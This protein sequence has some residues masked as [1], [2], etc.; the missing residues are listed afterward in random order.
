MIRD[1]LANRG[2]VLL[3]VVAIALGVAATV[4]S[5]IM[6][7]SI[8]TSLSVQHTRADVGVSVQMNSTGPAFSAP[9]IARLAAL[10]E[11]VRATGVQR[12]RAGVVAPNGKLVASA[13]VPEQAGTGWDD[14]GRFT[15][16]AGRAPHAGEIAVERATAEAGGLVL[17][18]DATVLL[19][20][21]RRLTARIVG[22]FDYRTLGPQSA[23]SDDET[24]ADQVPVAAFAA[25]EV[26]SVLSGDL[27]RIELALRPGADPVGVRNQAA[28]LVPQGHAFTGDQPAQAAT[29]EAKSE[30]N[31]LRLVLLPLS[32]IIVLVGIF[33]ITNSFTMLA[34]QRIRQFALLRAVG[35]HR[36]QIQAATILEAVGLAL[37]GGTLGVLA[38][39]GLA[40]LLLA[41]MRPDQ[42]I[43]YAGFPVAVLLGYAVA[44]V[45]TILAASGATRRAGRV[46][47]LAALRL[48]A[49]SPVAERGLRTW[50]GTG[51]VLAGVGLVLLTADPSADNQSRIIGL[52]GAVLSVIGV[53]MLSPR[54][55]A[56]G[57]PP[58]LR[59]V[60][61]WSGP[62]LRL[63]VR[64][65]ARNPRRT[66]G[67]GIA[68]TI[69]LT[70][71]CAFATLSATLDSLVGSSVRDNVPVSTT[72]LRS[73]AGGDSVLDPETLRAIAALPSVRTAAA[74][75][76]VYADIDHSGGTD[77]R[78][79]SIVEPEAIG[80]VLTPELIAGS[81]DLRSGI[82][83]SRNQADMLGLAVRDEVTLRLPGSTPIR[84]VV[85]GI[86]E[87]TEL[88]SSV[89]LDVNRVPQRL[90]D[91]ITL[92]YATGVDPQQARAAIERAVGDRP[93]I[94]VLD[95]DVLAD[96]YVRAQRFGFVLLYA[97][98]GL[99][100]LVA[101]FGVV[102]T[103]LLSVWERIPEIGMLRAIG[104]QRRLIQRMITAESLLICAFGAV[105][106]VVVGLW[107]GMVMQHV[108]FGQRILDATIPMGTI[109]LAL[110]GMVTAAV[111][112][113]FWPA[114]QASRV[115]VL[116][117][118]AR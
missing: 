117:A 73:A 96:D 90:Q 106:G 15:L 28:L 53:V 110:L 60:G 35:A 51:A 30:A 81:A 11:V 18:S 79:V 63:G 66:A 56:V 26:A 67:T 31:D 62:A 34:T 114:R 23:E 102:N 12:G 74:T 50:V 47:P 9:D 54:L 2:R 59:L 92:I 33:V 104:A 4:G 20:E 39:V 84:S 116:A 55:A 89:Y 48:D 98:F 21:Q 43:V 57:L 64:N 24:S 1:L 22:F 70:L 111:L 7:D 49:V 82:L 109:A 85:T 77:I 44:L 71:V 13:T 93:D 113:A 87:A 97:M 78:Q 52:S 58:V 5:W 101:V 100:I 69:G 8:A 3:T 27:V 61:R 65:A 115:S 99:A 14:T 38:G 68:I 76:N 86:Y 83:V 36:R 46:S 17:D 6:S 40:P 105:L 19:S 95:R 72:I 45:V 10:P 75:R 118:I 16:T 80:S 41:I 94:A 112:A 37:V 91:R 25:D 107:A 88:Q 108:V 29:D 32:G 42:Q 103:L